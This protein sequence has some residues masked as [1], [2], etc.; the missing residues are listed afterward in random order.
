ML[1]DVVHK[2]MMGL[3]P[4]AVSVA[5]GAGC[6]KEMQKLVEAMGWLAFRWW[7][8]PGDKDAQIL[9]D[10]QTRLAELQLILYRP[11]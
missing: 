7:S 1:E 5:V 11:T 2:L 6:S 8:A 9:K 3:T 10:V 4:D